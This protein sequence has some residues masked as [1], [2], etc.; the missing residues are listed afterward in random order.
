MRGEALPL[1]LA[2]C[3]LR[4]EEVEKGCL[5]LLVEEPRELQA[6]RGLRHDLVLQESGLFRR[7]EGELLVF[8][9]TTGREFSLKKGDVVELKES[10]QSLMPENFGETL[11][12]E[13]FNSLLAYLLSKQ[14]AK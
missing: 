13:D 4:V 8:A 6:A 14:A 9:D 12:Q 3:A 11:A 7:E 10:D 2:E 1:R 5:A